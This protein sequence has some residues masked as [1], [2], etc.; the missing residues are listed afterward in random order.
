[1]FCY[2]ALKDSWEICSSDQ[3]QRNLDGLAGQTEVTEMYSG[4]AREVRAPCSII[5]STSLASSQPMILF[6]AEQDTS[7]SNVLSGKFILMQ[8]SWELLSKA[9]II[10]CISAA[11][12]LFWH[13]LLQ[14]FLWSESQFIF[15]CIS[16]Q[17]SKLL[18][19]KLTK[20]HLTAGIC[21]GPFCS[22][23]WH[24]FYAWLMS[25]LTT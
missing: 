4:S 14:R 2:V 25:H 12:Y 22:Y 11:H 6:R 16:V 20:L 24:W 3:Q 15:Y 8:L 19:S 18:R 13:I 21:K 7:S 23:G 17:F 9:I 1:M 10:Y 5:L